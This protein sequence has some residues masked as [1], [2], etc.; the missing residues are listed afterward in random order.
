MRSSRHYDH[1]SFPFFRDTAG[2]GM[3]LSHAGSPF[4]C[5]RMEHAAK[6]PSQY[7]HVETRD[8]GWGCMMREAYDALPK[9]MLIS[10]PMREI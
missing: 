6:H 9:S 8:A 10:D 5:P 2:R 3:S 1:L 7:V 4:Y